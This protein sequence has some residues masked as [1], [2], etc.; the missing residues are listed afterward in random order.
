MATVSKSL[1]SLYRKAMHRPL[2]SDNFVL[3][4][5]VNGYSGAA[6]GESNAE[7]SEIYKKQSAIN[8]NSPTNIRK[9][10]ITGKGIAVQYYATPITSKNTGKHWNYTS[11]DDINLF[12]IAEKKLTYNADLSKY[13]MSQITGVSAT[14]PIN[15]KIDG[16]GI[17]IVS[18]PWVCNN[19][20]EIYFDWTMLISAEVAPYFTDWCTADG[21]TAFITNSMPS[22]E[23][24]YS[25]LLDFF[26]AFNSGGVKDLRKRFPRLRFIAMISRLHDIIEHPSMTKV[27]LEFSNINES[28]KTWYEINRNLVAESGSLVLYHDLSGDLQKPNKEFTI[29]ANQ[30]KFDYDKLDS[31]IKSYIVKINDAVREKYG[32][33]TAD[34][35]ESELVQDAFELTDVEKRCIEIEQQYG[36]K[37]LKNAMLFAMKGSSLTAAQVKKILEEFSKPNRVRM[38]NAIGFKDMQ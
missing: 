22:S 6:E 3:Y 29:K 13:K 7:K 9:I 5:K 30:Y 12:D 1:N 2:S 11:F 32:S 17:G 36:D 23:T 34:E 35:E 21:Y 16:N 19:I 31:V 25:R 20:E 10:F 24:Q 14:E 28:S 8:Y 33:A 37:V 38:A 27:D 26:M 15:Y 4:T 18:N